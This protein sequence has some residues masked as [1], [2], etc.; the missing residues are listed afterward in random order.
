MAEVK[1]W[2]GKLQP[3]DPQADQLKLEGLWLHQAHNVVNQELLRA[4]LTC[5][6]PRARAAATR[7]LCY[8]RER[9]DDSEELLRKSLNDEHPRVRI[10][11]VRAAS[12]YSKEAMQEPV[13]DVL[14]H[15]MDPFIEYA[16]DETVRHLES[17]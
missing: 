9:I 13:L 6:E 7:V 17:K 14:N 10:E 11:A 4:I 8:W 16:L 3:D 1:S 15:D 2:L 12:F 5:K